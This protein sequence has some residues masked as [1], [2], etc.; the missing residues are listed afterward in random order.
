[1]PTGTCE[2][3][4]IERIMHMTC[5]KDSYELTDSTTHNISVIL[6]T[7]HSIKY[8]DYNIIDGILYPIIPNEGYDTDRH[9]NIAYHIYKKVRI[10]RYEPTAYDLTDITYDDTLYD[11]RIPENT[12]LLKD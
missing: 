2:I 6:E 10:V 7:K 5:F 4:T 12:W 3:A 8:V 1:M 11:V 9:F